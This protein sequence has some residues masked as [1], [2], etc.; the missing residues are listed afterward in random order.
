MVAIA[1]PPLREAVEHYER[2]VA[3]LEEYRGF[4]AERMARYRSRGRDPNGFER[5]VT[6]KIG[7]VDE[8]LELLNGDLNDQLRWVVDGV[9]TLESA[10]QGRWV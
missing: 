5:V 8:L 3:S 9:G 2:L 10:D 4:L 6:N 7:R 1:H